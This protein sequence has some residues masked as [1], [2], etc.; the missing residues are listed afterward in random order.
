MQHPTVSLN[1]L[2][3][4]LSASTKLGETFR[5][6]LLLGAFSAEDAKLQPEPPLSSASDSDHYPDGVSR[7]PL[8]HERFEVNEWLARGTYGE[9]WRATDSKLKRPVAIK[10]FMGRPQEAHI[11]FSDEVKFVERLE[12]P[13]IPA[14]Y[15]IST[16]DEQSPFIVMQLIDGLTLKDVIDRLREGDED[17]HKR[18]HFHYRMDLIL[19]LLRVLSQI[20]EQ[21]IIH[22]DIKPE[23]LMLGKT[24]E[25]YL[26]DWGIAI[27]HGSHEGD[28]KISGTP[29][30][31]SP[32]QFRAE[33]A[34][35][36]SDIY[37]VGAVA[38]ELLTLNNTVEGSSVYDLGIKVLSAEI[39]HAGIQ[40]HPTQ[41]TIPSE[42][43]NLI[44][45]A[46]SLDPADRYPD[47]KCMR[48]DL[49]RVL[50]GYFDAVCTRTVI[51][52]KIYRYLRWIDVNPIPRIRLTKVIISVLILTIFLLGMGASLLIQSKYFF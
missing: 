13:G 10:S 38:Y 15:D 41:G 22:R 34:T 14:I 7:P 27:D 21:G 8:E 33:P 19:Q 3:D 36:K 43:A 2:P 30:Y 25:L 50:G 24:G 46:L 31:M 18:Y 42:F 40:T 29:L 48:L 17:T 6:N 9:V 16:S 51:K 45:K 4:D 12:H 28:G 5:N 32:E 47:A 26:M 23:N 37:S 44:M 1:H 52:Q 39:T 11:N 49:A 20:H 35:V